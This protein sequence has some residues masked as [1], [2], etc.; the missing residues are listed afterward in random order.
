MSNPSEFELIA[1]P[2]EQQKMAK[3]LADGI[4][5]WLVMSAQ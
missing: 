5:K 1:N 3:S 4:T 2:Q